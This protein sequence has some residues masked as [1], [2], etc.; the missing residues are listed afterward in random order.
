MHLFR[1][2]GIMFIL[3]SS[4]IFQHAQVPQLYFRKIENKEALEWA[5]QWQAE[6][7]GL[8]LHPYGYGIYPVNKDTVFFFGEFRTS[9]ASIRSFLLRSGD[10]GKIW[11]EVMLPV[12]G[13]EVIEMF[14]YDAHVGWA[15]VGWT[16]EGPGDLTL[17]GSTD[18]GKNWRKLSNIP[19][20]HFS[21]WPISMTF[22]DRRNG[23]IKILFDESGDPRTD[24]LLT[25]STKDGGR[26]W[27]EDSH[28]SLDQYKR[29]N[30]GAES[31]ERV[32]KGKDNSQWQVIGT[33]KEVRILRRLQADEV[34][35]VV[36]VIPSRFRYAKGEVLINAN[37]VQVKPKFETYGFVHRET[38]GI[39]SYAVINGKHLPIQ[40]RA[41]SDPLAVKSLNALNWRILLPNTNGKR[42]FLIGQY[43]AEPKRTARCDACPA[44]EEYHEFRLVHWYITT[45]FRIVSEDCVD[46]SYLREENLRTK[47]NLELSD[48]QDFEGRESIDVSR[49]QR[50]KR[51]LLPAFNK[52][53][54]RTRRSVND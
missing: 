20:L 24:G 46:C 6:Q 26:R 47:R 53:L 42:L 25:L 28:L 4:C 10:G 40:F 37:I 3:I 15:L 9:A 34:W 31:E 52:R 54:R 29:V 43:F 17:Y 21:G 44:V 27:H 23:V 11:R 14:F 8:A 22:S 32:V 48:F 36:C 51:I 39:T 33:D 1:L 41:D 38:T 2:L 18:G 5:S 13:S 50:K 35:R 7:H 49:F 12:Y 45:P 30:K 19:K 16:T